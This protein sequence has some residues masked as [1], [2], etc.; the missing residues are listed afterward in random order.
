L[1]AHYILNAIGEGAGER[2]RESLRRGTWDVAKD[3]P[4]RDAL[5]AGDLV[6]VYLGPPESEFIGRAELASSVDAGVVVL[7]DVEE[8]DPPA[9]MDDVL[10]KLASATAKAEFDDGVVRIVEHEYDTVLA[11]AAERAASL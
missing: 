7:D 10:S 6:L 4:R 9:P 11:V 2:A 3:E 5:A 1:T 8:W